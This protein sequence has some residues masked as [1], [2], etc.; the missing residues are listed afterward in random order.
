MLKDILVP[1]DGSSFSE[2]SLPYAVDTARRTGAKLHLVQVHEPPVPSA[3]PDAVPAYDERWDG[4]LRAQEQ[5]YLQSLAHRCMEHAGVSPVTEILDGPVSKVIAS[6]AAETDIDL[7]VMTTHG[8]GGISRAWVGSVADSLVRRVSVPVMLIRP[9]EQVLDWSRGSDARHVLIPLDGSAMAEAILEPAASLAKRSG[10]RVT[11]LRIVLPV[12][13]VIGPHAAGPA[14][15]EAGASQSRANAAQYLNHTASLLRA[16]GIA[17]TVDT[18]FHTVPAVGI[19]D[20]AATHAVD[21]I[22]MATHGRG[23]W[24]RIA[25]GSVADKVMRGSMMPVLLYRPGVGSRT[26]EPEQ[27]IVPG[28]DRRVEEPCSTP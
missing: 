3:Y 23:G 10:A 27:A 13:F 28:E 1:L 2:H 18:V 25:L 8:R 11:L 12:P 26:V 14:Y 15:S 24:S 16:R 21:T 6:Y 9:K 19:L 7:I 20:Y 22:A 5:E 17:V 4:A